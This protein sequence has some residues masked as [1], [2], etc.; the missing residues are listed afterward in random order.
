MNTALNLDFFGLD[1]AGSRK[2]MPLSGGTA[3]LAAAARP[4]V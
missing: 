1:Y 2:K 4:D 3:G